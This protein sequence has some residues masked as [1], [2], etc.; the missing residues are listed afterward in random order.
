MIFSIFTLFGGL[1]FFMYGMNQMSG[2][3]EKIAGEK[4]EYVINKMTSNRFM[5]LL[6]G[7]I[8]TIAIQSS[9]AVTVMLVGLVNSGLMSIANT[10]GVIMGSNI[11]TTITAWLMSLIGISSDNVAVR[12]L[13]PES[14]APVMAFIGIVLI[15]VSRI[16]KRKEVGNCMIGFAIL[17]YGMILMSSSV[18]PLADS[19]AFSK[20]LTAFET[21]ILGVLSGT[22]VTAVIQSSAASIGMLQALSLTGGITYGMAFPIIMGQNIGTCATA[23]LSSIGVNKNA[24]KVAVIHLSF[25]IIGT[26]IFMALY[27]GLNSIFDFAFTNEKITPMGIA[28]CHSIFNIGT[29]VLLL[30]FS[31]F[32]VKIADKTIKTDSSPDKVFLDERLFNTPS[33]AVA[34]CEILSAVMA[35]Y[36]KDGVIKVI[37]NY[38]DYHKGISDE[39][40]EIENKLDIFEDQIGSYLVKLIG[41]EL[42]DSDMHKVSK[43]LHSVDSF[44]RISDYAAE[45]AQSSFELQ[46][47][48]LDISQEA[49]N[50]LKVVSEAIREIMELTINAYKSNDTSV[51]KKVEPLE[52]TVDL[53]IS[54]SR[55][56]HTNRIQSGVCNL[57]KGFVFADT[58]NAFDRIADHCSN[59]ALAVLIANEDC[60]NQHEYLSKVTSMDNEN[61]KMKYA[62]Y[63][64]KYSL[65]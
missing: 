11:G 7:C 62:Y 13:K 55:A 59:I 5:G 6:L 22:V 2:S 14:F 64:S 47:K 52:R 45:L 27:Y 35:D 4:M 41:I 40:N 26:A 49:K 21:P 24:K 9:S 44:E 23:V 54:K 50:D 18:A 33:V 32:L 30:P 10:V 60:F 34:E 20:M 61:F 36:A 1:A 53:L 37:N 48:K 42:A 56:R 29:T 57:E 39:I 16:Q 65:K 31:R 25:N 17:M 51:A 8:I 19:P 38:F 28:L 15:M 12:M 46:N 63:Q 58:L 43:M 3:L